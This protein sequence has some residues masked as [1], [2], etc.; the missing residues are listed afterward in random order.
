MSVE[1]TGR[2]TALPLA[3]V[4]LAIPAMQRPELEALADRLIT[5]LNELDPD[6]DLEAEV[7]EDDS[8][9]C[10]EARDDGDHWHRA[11]TY[12]RVGTDVVAEKRTC[13]KLL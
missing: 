6:A 4:T 9:D 7:T 10:C 5:R 1:E 13:H 12:Q 11:P 2:A 8:E 3:I